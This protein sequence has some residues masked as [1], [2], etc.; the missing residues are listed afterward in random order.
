MRLN[1]SAD[2]EAGS[3]PPI[4]SLAVAP[5]GRRFLALLYEV[6]YQ[7]QTDSPYANVTF[8]GPVLRLTAGATVLHEVPPPSPAFFDEPPVVRDYGYTLSIYKSE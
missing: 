2:Y 3:G 6:E 1:F 4:C 5:Q 8:N 7:D